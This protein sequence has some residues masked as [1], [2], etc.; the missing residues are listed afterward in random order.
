MKRTVKLLYVNYP[1]RNL[2]PSNWIENSLKYCTLVKTCLQW[3]NQR[4]TKMK[5]LFWGGGK[6]KILQKCASTFCLSQT[7]SV[8]ISPNVSLLFLSW[9]NAPLNDK[10]CVCVPANFWILK[11]R[12][13]QY[14]SMLFLLMEIVPPSMKLETGGNNNPVRWVSI[15]I[16]IPILQ[17][18]ELMLR[19]RK[20][21]LRLSSNYLA[22]MGLK[23]LNSSFLKG[24]S[25]L[26]FLTAAATKRRYRQM[27][28]WCNKGNERHWKG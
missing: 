2:S 3:T 12:F 28:M 9:Q 20:A 22:K 25:R 4:P 21:C 19:E 15:C 26:G 10:C 16:I 18:G 1:N 8:N 14:I 24:F 13:V 5:S 23:L 11:E 6:A 7:E 27:M 17:K